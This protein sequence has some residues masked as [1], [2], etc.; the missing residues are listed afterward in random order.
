MNS[1]TITHDQS[2]VT[3]TDSTLIDA[4]EVPADPLTILHSWA[5][6]GWLRRLDSA[7]AA[8]MRELDPTASPVLLVSTAILAQM[9]GRG[10]TCL[11]LRLLVTQPDEVWAWPAMSHED[12]SALWQTM[13]S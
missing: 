9:E 2:P 1:F 6:K 5:D 11:P 10:H 3:M 13:P 12:L 8:F 7:L 4:A